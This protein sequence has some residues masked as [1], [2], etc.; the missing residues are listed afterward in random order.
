MS[1]IAGIIRFD[2]G[3]VEPGLIE[4]M[5]AAMAHRGPDGIHHWSRGSVALGHC[6]LHTTPESLEETQ[7]LANEDESL[8]LVMDGRIDNWEELRS[9]L[10]ALG[11]RLRTRADAELVL[12]AYE[13]WGRDCLQHMD[14]DFALVIWDARQRCAFCARD[15][16]GTK[17][18][19]YHW[20]RQCLTFAS[21][22]RP[23]LELPWTERVLNEGMVAE[24]LATEWHARDETFWQG[25][26][27]LVPA[28]A[29]LVNVEGPRIEEYWTPPLDAELRYKRAEEYAEHYRAL[30]FDAV[31]RQS[32]SHKPVG[33]EVSGGLDSSAVFAVGEHLRRRQLLLAPKIVGYTLYFG[34]GSEADEID[35]ARAVGHHFCKKISEVSPS[36]EP[37]SWHMEWAL[38]NMN[39]PIYPNGSFHLGI[40]RLSK[41]NGSSVLLTGI[42]G[43]QWLCGN[44]LYYAESIRRRDWK[45]FRNC[46][47]SD[48][49]KHG[50]LTC[51]QLILRHGVYP[52]LS[53]DIRSSLRKI[54]QR[55]APGNPDSI[56]LLSPRMKDILESRRIKS[57]STRYQV[58]PFQ[59]PLMI[60]LR[61][62]YTAYSLEAMESFASMS[63][64]ELR[65]PLY[66][67]NIINF[68]FSTLP[69]WRC[70]GDIDKKIHREAM[71]NVLPELVRTR[72]S[73]AVF[74]NVF[75]EY[76]E[77]IRDFINGEGSEIFDRD[78]VDEVQVKAIL[79][80][81]RAIQDRHW[82][83]RHIWGVFGCVALAK[84]D[85]FSADRYGA[86]CDGP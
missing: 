76:F 86:K 37:L 47:A 68:A 49:M 7:P 12:R 4:G 23:I 3:P 50:F 2:G 10:L 42:G 65:A 72:K 43:D 79:T 32:R 33:C 48:V 24:F 56:R 67:K 51:V 53:N 14:G 26:N 19:L 55:V 41:K 82:P 6:M 75:D 70:L 21:E 34:D 22:P 13:R 81:R 30:L 35:Y 38:C 46:V 84:C 39:F 78:W 18:L 5:T 61:S 16:I 40:H 36:R 64:L 20:D 44:R 54:Y 69:H 73:E 80:G 71:R 60:T 11:T 9:E 8:V 59:S 28:H 17:A 31:R 62:P 85:S 77:D 74:N 63:G 27:R 57:R 52:L 45:T 1:G 29:M 83:G 58:L 66:S 15:R 25:I